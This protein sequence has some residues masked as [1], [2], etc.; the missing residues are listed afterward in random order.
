MKFETNFR[1]GA[2]PQ[3]TDKAT[4]EHVLSIRPW[5]D[6]LLSFRT[7]RSRSFRFQPG[8]FVRLGLGSGRI[9]QRSGLRQPLVVTQPR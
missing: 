6:K 3:P 9:R 1:P 7:T 8:Q 2:A 4:L 5:C